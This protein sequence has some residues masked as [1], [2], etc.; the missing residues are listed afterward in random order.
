MCHTHATHGLYRTHYCRLILSEAAARNSKELALCRKSPVAVG[1]K[2]EALCSILPFVRCHH[3]T[4]TPKYWPPLVP[5]RAIERRIGHSASSFRVHV[6]VLSAQGVPRMNKTGTNAYCEV[7][8][9]RHRS[10]NTHTIHTTD[11]CPVWDYTWSFSLNNLGKGYEKKFTVE[12]LLN[13]K[14]GAGGLQV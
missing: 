7:R 14:K 2:D 4:D 10:T 5:P 6:C 12:L 1:W 8:C 3:S 11:G 9:G 13:D